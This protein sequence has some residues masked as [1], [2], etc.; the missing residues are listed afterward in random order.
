MAKTRDAPEDLERLINKLAA[1]PGDRKSASIAELHEALGRRSFGPLLVVP[2]LAALTPLG[3]VPGVP[4]LLGLTI[5]L[6]AVQLVFGRE[7]FWLPQWIMKRRVSAER[8]DRSVERVR[9]AVRVVDRLIKPRLSFLTRKPADRVAAVVCSLIALTIPPLE[10]V[11]FGVAA[12]AFA[13]LTFGL[14]LIARDGV[15]YLLALGVS[16]VSLFLLARSL[17]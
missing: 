4:S 11:P 2:A 17:L 1:A 15:L 9:P 7:S 8:L 13:I 16:G 5:L 14:G 10:L 6:V 3:I 12:P